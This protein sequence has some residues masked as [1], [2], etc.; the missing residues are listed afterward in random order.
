M[1]K[2]IQ[3]KSRFAYILLALFL[4]L[5]GIHNFYAGYVGRGLIQLLATLFLG[6]TI[7]IPTLILIWLLIEIVAITRDSEGIDFN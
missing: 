2:N 5:L 1:D 7:I 3:Q 4:G 6:W